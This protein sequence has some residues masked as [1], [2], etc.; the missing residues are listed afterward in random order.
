MSF[1]CQQ[2][3]P[4]QLLSGAELSAQVSPGLHPLW[5]EVHSLDGKTFYFS[6]FSGLLSLTPFAAPP[7]VKG[8]ILADEMVSLRNASACAH[9]KGA[10]LSKMHRS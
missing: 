3:T 6:P 2:H 10:E 7:P 4:A 8:G 9:M 1:S 5:R